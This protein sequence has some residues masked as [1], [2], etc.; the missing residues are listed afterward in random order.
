MKVHLP[1]DETIGFQMAPLI[2]CVFLL[3]MFFMVAARLITQT[4]RVPIE[5]PVAEKSVVARDF[6]GRLAI[7]IK[8]DGSIV[9]GAQVLTAEQVTE[10]VRARGEENPNVRIF[11]RA[12][13]NLAHKK[14]REV[15]KACADGGV[16][17]IIFSAYQSDK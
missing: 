5:V 1:P 3:V 14:V 4:E 7:T 16:G 12:D 15:M 9:S 6:S 2:D 17:D 11:L 8:E 13:K 10:M